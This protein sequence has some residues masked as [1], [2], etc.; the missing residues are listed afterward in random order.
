MESYSCR[1]HKEQGQF[2]VRNLF[3]AAKVLLDRCRQ[4]PFGTRPASALPQHRRR[5]EVDDMPTPEKFF[6]QGRNGV[7][8]ERAMLANRSRG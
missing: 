8:A 2:D 4:C 7:T 1:F 3:P 5:D 6:L